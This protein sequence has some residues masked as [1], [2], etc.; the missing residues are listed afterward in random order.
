[1]GLVQREDAGRGSGGGE[2]GG[3]GAYRG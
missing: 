1:M 3:L 2:R